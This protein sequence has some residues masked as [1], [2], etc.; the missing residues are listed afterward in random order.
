MT[1]EA[2]VEAPVP[3]GLRLDVFISETMGLFSR[4]QV[5]S[6]VTE[7]RVNGKSVRLS[8]KL[9]AGDVVAV[10]YTH[11]PPISAEPENIPLDVIFEN[12]DVVVVNKPQGMVVHP[13]SGNSTGTL[14]NALLFH[15]AGLSAAF[16]AEEIRPGIVHRLDKETSGVI[17]M[18]KN[19]RAHELLSAQFKARKTRKLYAAI[20]QGGLKEPRGRLE[21]MI[22]R[23]TAHRK[24]FACSAVRGRHSVTLWK[25]V[26][27]YSG[28]PPAAPEAAVSAASAASGKRPPRLYTLVMLSPKTGRTHQLRVHMRHLSAP[29]LGDELYGRP[30]PLFPQARLMLH[31]KSLTILL[32]GEERPRTFR[33]PLP[34]RFREILGSQSLSPR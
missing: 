32:P 5:K 3:E 19:P 21:T 8:R 1:A 30:D 14:V 18:A 11:A 12:D 27:T 25:V 16:G 26:R 33:A 6:R 4:S 15:C 2:R 9:K 24:R 10:D 7:V 28:A 22:V 31:A 23:D 29:V 13:G 34:G 20:L 17:I